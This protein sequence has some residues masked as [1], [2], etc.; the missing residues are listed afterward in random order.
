MAQTE[1]FNKLNRINTAKENIKQA[2]IDKGQEPT[3][4]IEDYAELVSNISDVKLFET[5]EE[6]RN[7]H[8]P[9]Q[10]DMAVIYGK[11]Y[12]DL[13]LNTQIYDTIYIPNEIELPEIT[14]THTIIIS[15]N[16]ILYTSNNIIISPTSISINKGRRT[17][18][19]EYTSTDGINYTR[20]SGYTTDEELDPYSLLSEPIYING[21]QSNFEENQEL[22]NIIIKQRIKRLEGLYQYNNN[23]WYQV[24]TGLSLQYSTQL[25]PDCTALGKYGL[26]TG[27]VNTYKVLDIDKVHKY[28]FEDDTSN[29][30]RV[31][32]TEDNIKFKSFDLNQPNTSIGS[33]SIY[34]TSFTDLNGAIYQYYIDI[35]R[36]KLYFPV[37]DSGIRQMYIKIIDLIT[38]ESTNTNTITLSGGG[39]TNDC[40]TFE[41]DGILY[42]GI[43]A[44]SNNSNHVIVKFD[45]EHPNT[46]TFQLFNDSEI[47][48]QDG[49]II[50]SDTEFYRSYAPYNNG[51]RPYQYVY[52]QGTS[53]KSVVKTYQINNKGLSTGLL[54]MQSK[55]YVPVSNGTNILLYNPVNGIEI[56]TGRP[57]DE[58]IYYIGEVNNE[59]LVITRK[60]CV[61]IK[62]NILDSTVYFENDVIPAITEESTHNCNAYVIGNY[63]I[64]GFAV[65]NLITYKWEDWSLKTDAVDNNKFIY[66]IKDKR[67][68]TVTI[69][70]TNKL[71]KLGIRIPIKEYNNIYEGEYKVFRFSTGLYM[72]PKDYNK[73]F[74]DDVVTSEEFAENVSLLN[75][76]LDEEV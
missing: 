33:S 17:K 9:H 20:N 8:N 29:Y 27:S 23:N 75:D 1:F 15:M 24:D 41:K 43:Q 47:E 39:M 70:E 37:S 7:Y 51:V 58:G 21:S 22:L 10:D 48:G 61:I 68:K 3:N 19:L 6:M 64:I 72:T 46:L 14:N 5:V 32:G 56:D 66:E 55:L 69:D 67:F 34:S 12:V 40:M 52:R 76:I 4:N 42:F 73:V 35:T 36:N 74:I 60:C 31:Y 62:N 26:I 18:L 49:V 54:R 63:L 28:L 71:I 2:L 65:F 25:L 50:I 11:R 30:E 44:P 59:T 57:Y 38:G 13:Q 16:Q 53:S 45:P